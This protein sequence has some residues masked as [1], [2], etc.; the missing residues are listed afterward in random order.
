MRGAWGAVVLS[1]LPGPLHPR[2]VFAAD[3]L[4]EYAILLAQ[5]VREDGIDY[6]GL[7]AGRGALDAYVHALATADPG[8]TGPD[9]IA[10][11]INAHNALALQ[12]AIDARPVAGET[13]AWKVA[14]R[15]VTLDGI[16]EIL[17]EFREPLVHF[18]LHRAS[19]SSP[20]LSAVPYEGR[21][22]ASSLAQQTR[23]FLGDPEKNLFE[24]AQLRAELSMLILWH[25][26]ELEAGRQGDVPPLQLFLA[27]H[28][29]REKEEQAAIARSLRTTRWD[30]SYR[31]YDWSPDDVPAERSTH[32]AW[33][34]LYGIAAL[35]LLFLGFRAFRGL[36]RPP[37]PVPPH[38]PDG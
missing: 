26:K 11:W 2:P 33:L 30:I 15:D 25:R 22:L 20:P 37:A 23:A 24:Y 29:P 17:K 8:A 31:P 18:A 35:A 7:A 5:S 36:L 27:D 34:I 3:T 10:F 6:A 9:R 14:G 32:P 1:L 19:R 4:G 28:L 13:R 12:Q 16:E 38:P 21:D